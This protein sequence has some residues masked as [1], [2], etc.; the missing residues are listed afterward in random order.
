MLGHLGS[1]SLNDKLTRH[2]LI[3][4]VC[5]LGAGF[6]SY[7][8]Q[9]SMGILLNTEQYGVLFSLTSLIT[10]IIVFSE[11]VTLAVAKFTAAFEGEDRIGAIYY[12]WRRALTRATLSGLMI[13]AVAALASPVIIRFLNI[14]R[15]LFLIL[16][17]GTILFVFAL[18]VNWGIMQ[19]VQ[20]FVSLGLTQLF[21]SML[22]AGLGI[23]LVLAGWGIYGGLAAFPIAFL[24]TLAISFIPLRGLSHANGESS[25]VSRV[26]TNILIFATAVIFSTTV[27]TNV[28]VIM[29]KHYLN[30]TE[31][32]NYSLIAILGRI[33]YYAPVS[34]AG[35]MFP[36]TA[37]LFQGRRRYWPVLFKSLALL[38][39]VAGVIL[40]LY[41]LVPELITGILIAHRQANVAPFIFEYGLAMALFAVAFLLAT[42]MLSINQVKVAYPLLGTVAIQIVLLNLFH[43]S[44]GQLVNMLL[45]S[46]I[47]CV[48]VMVLCMWI[49]QRAH[50]L[51]SIGEEAAGMV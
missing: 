15:I 51:K 28:D 38:V 20:N 48:V 39:L 7:V 49:G 31:A 45:V 29:A 23:V 33:A 9:F 14:D 18:S 17:F 34:I 21:L 19:G 41:A 5:G 42:F 36:K 37:A 40:L 50:H 16:P 46:S 11:S 22:R 44:L 10:I 35:A 30:A 8:F 24:V 2:S 27:L 1:G 6:F 26:P 25:L 47:V 32:G 4:L 12:F 3:M 43:N 13:F